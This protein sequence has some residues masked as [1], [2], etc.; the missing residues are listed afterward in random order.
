MKTLLWRD[1][2][3]NGQVLSVGAILLLLPYLFVLIV[4]LWP[5]T[6]A[7]EP[8]TIAEGVAV[9]AI[10]S[11]AL[12]Q[13]TVALLGGN[14]IA[15]ERAD[16]SAE[17]MAY[18]PVSKAS[19]LAGKLSLTVIVT[20]LVWG[21]NLL[22]LWGLNKLS[23]FSFNV[24]DNLTPAGYIILTG[25]LMF[26]VAWFVSSMQS[27]PSLAVLLGIATPLVTVLGLYMV[28]ALGHDLAPETF[29]NKGIDRFWEIGF[30]S[31]SL[32]LG[33]LGFA[34]GTWYFLKR[35]EP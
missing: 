26:G 31:I 12:S 2:R 30:T 19:R 23:L 27:S 32:V 13:L 33:T 10:W 14:A 20:V 5:K 4:F 28:Y 3:L 22:I 17:F 6:N 18:L 15:G 16:R 8:D 7:L 24:P 25:F 29:D 21:I 34:I 9:A 11:I 1:Y 35:V